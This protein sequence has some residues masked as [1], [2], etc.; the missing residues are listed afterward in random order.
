MNTDYLDLLQFHGSPPAE[1]REEA[2]QAMIGLKRD[3][4]ARFISGL[5]NAKQKLSHQ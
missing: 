5:R 4:K 3:G 2:V 1:L